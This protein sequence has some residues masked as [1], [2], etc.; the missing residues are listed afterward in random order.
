MQDT[1]KEETMSKLR[2]SMTRLQVMLKILEHKNN[3]FHVNFLK[4]Q[5]Y[6][7]LVSIMEHLYK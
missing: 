5:R 6:S 1:T 4:E 7:D 3:E 2:K